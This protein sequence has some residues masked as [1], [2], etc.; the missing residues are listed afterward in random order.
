[1]S[2]VF[3]NYLSRLSCVARAV[4]RTPSIRGDRC[5]SHDLRGQQRRYGV[6]RYRMQGGRALTEGFPLSK[7]PN[8][9]ETTTAAPRRNPLAASQPS[10]QPPL[11]A[12]VATPECIPTVSDYRERGCMYRH[13]ADKLVGV[14]AGGITPFSKK[15]PLFLSFALS[16]SS[17]WKDGKLRDG[18]WRT[19]GAD[20]LRA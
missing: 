16:V 5:L 12:A 7:G 4:S 19:H 10:G 9:Q 18:R 1:M 20:V 13:A 6:L 17:Y 11:V 15:H 8:P 2:T 3:P 14:S